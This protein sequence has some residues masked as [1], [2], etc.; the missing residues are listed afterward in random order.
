MKSDVSAITIIVA[1]CSFFTCSMTVWDPDVIPP[2]VNKTASYTV[3]DD[4]FYLITCFY[5]GLLG[6][7]SHFYEGQKITEQRWDL[8]VVRNSLY[9]FS[10]RSN[11]GRYTCVNY[12]GN[13]AWVS[14]VNIF[15]PTQRNLPYNLHVDTWSTAAA[16]NF[17]LPEENVAESEADSQT[18]MG[19]KICH[20]LRLLNY[21]NDADIVEP[22]N[23]SRDGTNAFTVTFD[24]LKANTYYKLVALLPT[25]ADTENSVDEKLLHIFKTYGK[26][27]SRPPRSISLSPFHAGIRVNFELDPSAEAYFSNE[28]SMMNYA[29]D[30]PVQGYVASVYSASGV[31]L[32]E[33]NM[34]VQKLHIDYPERN[35]GTIFLNGLSPSETYGVELRSYD[36]LGR[37][38][39]PSLRLSETPMKAEVTRLVITELIIDSI[40]QSEIQI[41]WRGAVSEYLVSIAQNHEILHTARVAIED[42]MTPGGVK[43]IELLSSTTYEIAIS[44]EKESESYV[45]FKIF[46]TTL[47]KPSENSTL[48]SVE[49]YSRN[50]DRLKVEIHD[51]QKEIREKDERSEATSQELHRVSGSINETTRDMLKMVAELKSRKARIKRIFNSP[52]NVRRTIILMEVFTVVVMLIAISTKMVQ[53][54]KKMQLNSPQSSE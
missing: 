38:S 30:E 52:S 20:H 28:M 32:G 17:Q 1:C 29:D 39:P 23:K 42:Y 7:T 47:K 50:I 6:Q 8:Y 46:I 2:Y 16:V 24:G 18:W 21:N 4:R 14:E 11:Q 22:R 40:T 44:S 51:I 26:P 5:Q 54:R 9:V 45:P 31:L 15:A 36:Q 43:F 35:T 10:H 33:F 41:K 48:Y 34:T 12:G 27:L 37:R 53:K 3:V 49:E 25:E 13:G 19:C